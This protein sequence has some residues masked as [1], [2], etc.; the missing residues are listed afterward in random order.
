MKS[1]TTNN[2]IAATI[3]NLRIQGPRYFS[4]LQTFPSDDILQLSVFNILVLVGLRCRNYIELKKLEEENVSSMGTELQEQRDQTMANG[5]S[6]QDA[7]PFSTAPIA[8]A[9]A[10]KANSAPDGVTR[11][12]APEDSSAEWTNV[13]KNTRTRNAAP[14][15]SL[16]HRNSTK[17]SSRKIGPANRFTE[18]MVSRE[19]KGSDKLVDP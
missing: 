13:V 5:V 17:N 15:P 6:I 19:G 3:L 4:H 14:A 12:L 9:V 1:K 18:V 11:S 7:E 16:L 10:P 2:S 8:T